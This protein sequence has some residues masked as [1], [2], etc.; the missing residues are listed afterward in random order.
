MSDIPSIK[1]PKDGKRLRAAKARQQELLS[2]AHCGK[3]TSLE[4]EKRRIEREKEALARRKS[5]R[6][7]RSQAYGL[8]VAR[9]KQAS[10]DQLM[11][12]SAWSNSE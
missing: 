7:Q 3:E 1:V 2:K 11:A 5:E 10:L 12:D 6:Y 8:E 4:V 9:K